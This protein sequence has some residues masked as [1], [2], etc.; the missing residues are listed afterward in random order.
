MAIKTRNEIKQ[1]FE[2]NDYPEQQQFWDWID[3]FRHVSEMVPADKVEGISEMLEQVTTIYNQTQA[4]LAPIVGEF[5][6]GSVKSILIPENSIYAGMYIYNDSGHDCEFS[7]TNNGEGYWEQ[8]VM[9]TAGK[10]SQERR[11]FGP[12]TILITCIS[13]N[14]AYKIFR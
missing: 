12:A 9:P 6:S 11:I 8:M 4:L 13:G 7:I 2:T 5:D 10:E 3:S 14:A 1:W